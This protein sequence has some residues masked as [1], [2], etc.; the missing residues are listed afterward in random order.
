MESCDGTALQ[1]T[2][3]AFASIIRTGIHLNA[4]SVL[5]LNNFKSIHHEEVADSAEQG[6]AE[7]RFVTSRA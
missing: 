2:A 3:P 6:R 7:H 1:M 4:N 5:T